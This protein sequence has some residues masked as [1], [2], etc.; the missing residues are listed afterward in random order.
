LIVG[1]RLQFYHT[2]PFT[3]ILRFYRYRSFTT[4]VTVAFGCYVLR[5][6]GC[7]TRCAHRY[8]H[9]TV[10]LRLLVAVPGYHYGYVRS[11]STHFTF[12]FSFT[13]YVCS[14]CVWFWLP[15]TVT[16]AYVPAVATGYHAR[17]TRCGC[18]LRFTR[19]GCSLHTVYVLR[20]PLVYGLCGLRTRLRFTVATPSRLRILR[21]RTHCV[22]WLRCGYH[23]LRLRL[24]TFTVYGY[25]TTH[26]HGYRTT[27]TVGYRGLP[28]ALRLHLRTP[29]TR[30]VVT[31]RLRLPFGY[32]S[33]PHRCVT[34]TAYAFTLLHTRTRLLRVTYRYV[35]H[36]RLHGSAVLPLVGAVLV[37]TTYRFTRL[38][39][40]RWIRLR[41][42]A[43]TTAYTVTFAFTH[44]SR[45]AP[46]C[47]TTH[48][49][50]T[51]LRFALRYCGCHVGL[52]STFVHGLRYYTTVHVADYLRFAVYFTVTHLRTT[53]FTLLP[54]A[55]LRLVGSH[56]VGLPFTTLRSRYHVYVLDRLRLWFGCTF[57]FCTVTHGW[58]RARLHVCLV[59]FTTVTH[60][61]LPFLLHT[62]VYVYG[63]RLHAP[64]LPRL[65]FTAHYCVLVTVWFTHHTF[66]FHIA[67]THVG[68]WFCRLR[69]RGTGFWILHVCVHTFT[70]C[71]TPRFVTPFRS[72][73]VTDAPVT[74]CV[75][76][77]YTVTL[78]G[79]VRLR[80]RFTVCHGFY[81]RLRLGYVY[82]PPH[83]LLHCGYT[84]LRVTAFAF[85]P[86][87]Y[88]CLRYHVVVTFCLPHVHAYGCY[89]WLFVTVVG[90]R[91]VTR[92]GC[93]LFTLRVP[94][95]R[96]WTHGPLRSRLLG[97][98]CHAPVDF[99]FTFRL[100]LRFV[101]LRLRSFHVYGYVYGCCRLRL[102]FTFTPFAVTAVTL[103]G[104]VATLRLVTPLGYVCRLRYV[105]LHLH[106][107]TAHTHLTGL[108]HTVHHRAVTV[109]CG[110]VT[111]CSY[112]TARV[113][114]LRRFGL[115]CRGC[116]YSLVTNYVVTFTT[117][118]RT[119][120]A[121]DLRYILCLRSA[122]LRWLRLVRSRLRFCRTPVYHT[123]HVCTHARIAVTHV[124][125][126]GYVTAVTHTRLLPRYTHVY[127]HGYVTHVLPGY[128]YV[129]VCGWLP[130]LVGYVLDS[131]GWVV[132]R[133]FTVYRLRLRLHTH[134]VYTHAR[135]T[136]TARLVTAHVYGATPVTAPYTGWL[137]CLFGLRTFTRVV[138]TP[139]YGYW[140]AVTL[141]CGLVLVLQLP[142]R[143][144][145]VQRFCRAFRLR[146]GYTFY[147]LFTCSLLP[148]Y[149][150]GSRT[151]ATPRFTVPPLPHVY[152]VHGYLRLGLPFGY[153]A[154]YCYTLGYTHTHGCVC[155]F[156]LPH[157]TRLPV[158][159]LH[160]PHLLHITFVTTF[161][162]HTHTHTHLLHT[163]HYYIYITRLLLLPL[164]YCCCYTLLLLL[165]LL[166]LHLL[167]RWY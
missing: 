70:H 143:V 107:H 111:F 124:V 154:G 51:V 138:Y 48:T 160:L 24:Y 55:R 94:G 120:P 98:T 23:R 147:T 66:A 13:G 157:V 146:V 72:C 64:R 90:L 76:G 96:F 85:T 161:H 58:L 121:V 31:A 91:L 145:A 167:L 29:H 81:A 42:P 142:H 44:G 14:T 45:Y 135:V 11:S 140:I 21:L 99:A 95:L 144:T 110:L 118:L 27:H 60:F 56:T 166:L 40:Y 151:H 108:P 61:T 158:C 65:R 92:F 88:V 130:R 141:F 17:F 16:V 163:T 68:C 18:V 104:Y 84:G 52:R 28:A 9:T 149:H 22:G 77:Y 73:V 133:S 115:R 100:P 57:T 74:V 59:T 97:Y 159:L 8:L 37:P 123:P 114:T 32:G 105:W 54:Y 109:A 106:T 156:S 78:H 2:L 50:F 39:I 26:A 112:I 152:H 80:L 4:S 162:T 33:T 132:I 5:L 69:L 127:V 67:V 131:T 150:T 34:A 43:V 46:H 139:V 125:H 134:T 102:R 62:H 93:W 128:G 83:R 47:Y 12:T 101:T 63:A 117:R 20:L 119:V 7:G 19:C 122:G 87:G 129:A 36:T 89:R 38:V 164:F 35:T 103:H 10:T 137:R 3:C 25:F 86:F 79:Y 15:H 49:G 1:S 116:Y 75:Y 82:L 30:T 153:T 41:L 136:V 113:Y 155:G 126:T 6:R 71:V 53:R 148:V 165:H